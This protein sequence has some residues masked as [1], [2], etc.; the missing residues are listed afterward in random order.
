MPSANR[1]MIQKRNCRKAREACY[2]N[3][4][5]Q[6]AAR[7]EIFRFTTEW[8]TSSNPRDPLH[9]DPYA[10]SFMV[11]KPCWRRTL[12]F[13]GTVTGHCSDLFEE[14]Y[15]PSVP[16]HGGFGLLNVH[17]IAK[18]AW[19]AF[20]LLHGLGTE[21]MKVEGEHETV[22]AWLVRGAK[23]VTLMLTNFALP[24]HTI[25]DETVHF[26]M[27]DAASVTQVTIQKIDAEHANA[28]QLWEQME[29]P[30]Y[31]DARTIAELSDASCV[32]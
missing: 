10:A 17:G 30:E 22:D 23:S 7:Q 21:L 31:L 28:K 3:R 2:A 1:M 24:R 11:R 20:E 25:A 15:F 5:V 27:R 9:D 13:K 12:W 4:H 14:N 16:F 18:P 26:E 6:C 29:T 32:F 8:C 19:R